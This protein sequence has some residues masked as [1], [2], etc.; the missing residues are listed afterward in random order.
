MKIN[1]FKAW[2]EGFEEA[3][4]GSPTKAQWTKIKTRLQSVD[5]SADITVIEKY[6]DYP[7][8]PYNPL[9]PYWSTAIPC[10][11]TLTTS[12]T[13]VLTAFTEVGKLEAQA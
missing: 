7:W 8:D 13:N 10:G 1:E 3:I 5:G 6:K 2:L 9:K 4:S 12:S 11:T